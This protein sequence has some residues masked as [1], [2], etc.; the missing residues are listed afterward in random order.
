MEE[1]REGGKEGEGRKVPPGGLATFKTGV[2]M[3]GVF[4]CW[5]EVVIID[6]Y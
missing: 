5:I 1:G 2:A 6:D 4:P 3:K